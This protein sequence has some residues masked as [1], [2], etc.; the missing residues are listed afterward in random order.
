MV[1]VVSG[2]GLGLINSSFTALGGAQGSNL[3]LGQSRTLQAVNLASGNLILQDQDESLSVRGFSTNFLRTYNSQGTVAGVGQDGWVTGYERKVALTSGTLNVAGSK[4]TLY[5]GDGQSQIFTYV[6]ANNYQS[7]D[8]DGAHDSLALSGTTWTYT[9][10]STRRQEQYEDHASST[11]LG[12]LKNISY[13]KSDGT[14]PAQY[15][16]I[17]NNNTATARITEVQSIDGSGSTSDAILFTYD[18]SGRLSAIS[19]REGGVTKSQVSYGYDGVGRLSWI[20]QDLTPTVSGDNTWDAATASNNNGLRFRT[21]YTYVTT[22]STDLRIASV[23]QSDGSTISYTYDASSRIQTVSMGGETST[24][25]YTA[26]QTDVTDSITGRTWSYIYDANKQLTQVLAPAIS[27]QRDTTSYTYDA[28]GNVTQVK[29]IRASTVLSQV[30]YSYD[31]NGN[32]LWQWNRINNSDASAIAVQRTYNS[33]NQVLTETTFTGIDSDGVGVALPSGGLVKNFIYDAQNRLRFTV[34][35]TGQVTEQVYAATGNGIGQAISTR[36]YVGNAYIGVMDDT[37]LSAWSTTTKASS[38]LTEY[39]YDVKGRLQQS[40]AYATVNASG[41]GVLDISTVITSYGYDAQNL[42]LQQISVRGSGRTTT[43][44]ST[45]PTGS[46]VT[47]YAY[48]GMGRLLS[49]LK[50]DISSAAGTD[51]LTVAS[52]YTYLDSGNQI[53]ITQDSGATQTQTRNSA[54]RVVSETTAGASMV[55]RTTNNYYDGAGQLRASKDASGGV[56]YYFYDAKGRLEGTVDPTGAVAQFIYDGSDRILST[57][58]YANAVTTTTWLSGSVVTKALFADIGVVA[59]T[60]K[61]RI[62]T[63][64]YDVV[65]RLLSQTDGAIGSVDRKIINYSYDGASRVTQVQVTDSLGTA[66]TARTSRTLYDAAG[67]VLATIDAEGY[68]SENTYDASGLLLSTIRYANKSTNTTATSVATLRPVLDSSNDQTTR[69]YFDGRGQLVGVLDAQGILAETIVDELGNTR[70]ELRYANSITWVDGDSL[71]SLRSRAGS[72]R[73]LTRSAYNGLGQLATQTNVEGTVTRFSYDEAGRLVRTEVAADTTDVR[74]NFSRY[75]VFDEVIGE[76]SGEQAFAAKAVSANNPSGLALNDPTLTETQKDALY[77]A[78]GV[79]HSLDDLGRRIESI[80]A[81]GNKT[82]YFYDAS[83]RQ[84]FVVRGSAQNNSGVS[85]A[86]NAYAEVIETRYDAFGAV[87]DSIAYTGKITVTTPGSRTSVATAIGTLT[88][89]ASVDSKRSLSYTA[90]GLLASQTDAEGVQSTFTY[91]AFG[92]RS[93]QV[94]ANATTAQL[95]QSFVYDK[96]GLLLSNSQSGSGV[97]TRTSSQSYDAFGRII[98][99]I[100]ARGSSRTVTYDRL[101]RVLSQNMTVSGQVESIASSYD[102]YSRVLSVTD[103]LGKVTSYSYNDATRSMTI[104]SPEGVVVSTVHNRHGQSITVSDGLNQTISTSYDKNGNVLSVTDALNH[105]TNNTYD[106]R[107]MLLQSTD[108]DGNSVL[109]SYDAAGRVLTRAVDPSGLNLITQMKYDGQGRSVQVTDAAGR[110][111]AYSYD[112]EGRLT[113]LSVDSSGLNLRTKYSYDAAGRQTTVEEGYNGTTAQK[114]TRYDYDVLGRRTAEHVDPNGLNITT[115]YLYD[116][117]DN[118]IKR[119]DAAGNI[120][121]FVYDE[122]NRQRY[123]IGAMGSVIETAYDKTG[124]VLSS[125]AYVNVI[126]LTAA[127][128]TSLESSTGIAAQTL[129]AGKLLSNAADGL[130]NYIY[131]ND[132]RLKQVGDALGYLT[133]YSYDAAGNRRS[134]TDAMGNVTRYVYDVNNQLR[135]S[136]DAL[137]TVSETGYDNSGQVLSVR[138]YANAISLTAG[139][140]T[141]LNTGLA[142]AAQSLVAGKLLANNALDIRQSNTYDNAGRLKQVTDALGNF[143]SYTYNA[144]GN[145]VT[146]TNKLGAVWTYAYDAA[147]RMTSETSPVVM[148]TTANDVGVVT[149]ISRSVVTQIVYDIIGN[150]IKRIEDA[151]GSG[152]QARTT[153]YFYD[154]AG[155]Q[156]KTIFPDAGI[157]NSSGVLVT[158]GIKPQIEVSFNALN[159]A[160]VQK[161]VR[162]NHAYK[163]YDVLGRLAYDVDA[164]GY[165]SKYSFDALGQQTGLVRYAA[166]INTG[167][168]VGW[169]AGQAIS[170]SQIQTASVLATGANDRTIT[171]A[172]DVRGYKASVLLSAIVAYDM[173]G[174]N[175]SAATPT[176][177][178]TYNALGQLVKESVLVQQSPTAIWANTYHYYDAAGRERMTVDAEGYVSET[179]YNA[180]GQATEVIQYARAINTATLTQ[181][182]APSPPAAGDAASGYDRITRYSYDA[183]GRKTSETVVSHYQNAD[184]S[185]AVRDVA[186]KLNYDAESRVIKL[187]VD[188]IDTQTQYDALGRVINVQEAERDVLRSDA[189][190]KIVGSV[191]LDLNSSS[192]Y[193]RSSPYT[194]LTYDAFGNQVKV[195][196]YANGLRNGVLTADAA[197]DQTTI[198]RYDYQGRSVMVLDTLGNKT[199]SSYDAADNV[200]ESW[201]RLEGNDGRFSEVRTTAQYDKVGHQTNSQTVR[202][203]Y[204]TLNGSTVSQS[205]ANDAREFVSYNAFGEVISKGFDGST[206]PVLFSYDNAGRL[207]SSNADGG[208]LKTYGYSVSGAQVRESHQALAADNTVT[209]AVTLQY[210]DKL[211][212]AIRFNTPSYSNTISDSATVI[213][214]LDRW[215]NVLELT[216]PRGYLTRMEYNA[217]NQV[218]RTITP[219]VLVVNEDGTAVMRQPEEFTY[220]DALGRVIAERDAN[221][222]IDRTEYNAV[223]QVS[224]TID[225]M[226]NKTLT[227]FDALGNQR[228]NQDA[229]G[230]ITYQAFDKL[231]RVSE[232]GDFLPTLDGTRR[233]QLAME[234]YAINQLGA[235]ISVTDAANAI[236]KYDYDSR[237]LL[238]RSE[239]ALGIK[240]EY[241]YDSQGRKIREINALSDASLAPNPWSYQT[242]TAGSSTWS[243]AVPTIE[244]SSKTA[245]SYQGQIVSGYVEPVLEY[246][247]ETGQTWVITEGYTVYRSLNAGDWIQFNAGSQIFSGTAPSTPSYYYM[248]V[249]KTNTDGSNETKTFIVNV[250]AGSGV[251]TDSDGEQVRLHEQTWDYDAFGRLI[252]HNDLSGVDYNYNYNAITNQQISQSSGWTTSS[253]ATTATSLAGAYQQYLNDIVAGSYSS[254]GNRTFKFYT[255]GLVKEISEGSNV[256]RYEYDAAGN[257]TLEESDITDANGDRVKL[258][259]QMTYDSHNRLEHIMQDD[260]TTTTKRI[261]DLVYSYDANGNRRRVQAQGA[262]L[263]TAPAI[264]T[265]NRAPVTTATAPISNKTMKSGVAVSF[266]ILL[267]DVFRDADLDPLAISVTQNNGNPL[268]TWLTTSIDSATGELV[269][270]ASNASVLGAYDIKVKAT[271]TNHGASNLSANTVFRINVVTNSA[272]ALLTAGTET[273]NLKLNQAMSLELASAAYFS[274][275]D[276]G[277]SLTLSIFSVSPAAPWLQIDASNPNA[278]RLSGT[279][280]SAG[281]YTIKLRGTDASGAFVD[282]TISLVVSANTAPVGLTQAAVNFVNGRTFSWSQPLSSV[283]TDIDGNISTLTATLADG[284]ALPNWMSLETVYKADGPYLV[285][286]GQSPAGTPNN[287]IYGVKFTAVDAMGLSGSTQMNVLFK[288]NSAPTVIGTIPAQR[289]FRS[290]PY[291]ATLAL[292]SLFSDTD[293]DSLDYSVVLPANSA[294]ASWLSYVVDRDAGTIT[295]SGTPPSMT[296]AHTPLSYV[297]KTSMARVPAL[298]SASI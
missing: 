230:Y 70:A 153:E 112:R 285:L 5:T 176:T 138:T 294:L 266:R 290:V 126:S 247:Q 161:D 211:G 264:S 111:T 200:L 260:F 19:T 35:A 25:T 144:V 135:Y 76:I 118:V 92:E 121:R 87:R 45:P 279:P 228:L 223:G 91:N 222:N 125:R 49:I 6:S 216:D 219:L 146:K 235:R 265:A 273:K 276:L 208:V 210:I 28:S 30:D 286:A 155:R 198:S 78:Y 96:R 186:T 27:G 271:E 237:N 109:Y 95:T 104:T 175:S 255:N 196:R 275:A 287:T 226:G 256:Y 36:T 259:T 291:T 242:I 1:A 272:P 102:A 44:T 246:D 7:T 177:Q 115:N 293:T 178:F 100:D 204:R 17:Y 130:S 250:L 288:N 107:G 213:Q 174:A 189:E 162:G 43:Y 240:M 206:Q 37:S 143:E 278:I 157:I 41:V 128:I 73:Q 169:S 133:T 173:T 97:T 26:N 69:F 80:D 137:G 238:V 164:E 123:S 184:G 83:S 105:T 289:I 4:M 20:Q 214:R 194:A 280:T 132:G 225:A 77:A 145:R 139:D 21:T 245:S 253:V 269:F 117:N 171:T 205:S 262:L 149:N 47:S 254:T 141:T 270:T 81:Q 3:L 127:N 68:V 258:R 15:N 61:D 183:L 9:E 257:R 277:D 180:L 229:N 60:N 150:V 151:T 86:Q 284:S 122:A 152:A 231:G 192:L 268:P 168:M 193:E 64:I 114:T 217:V 113:L 58:R 160:V 281:T 131:D 53:V 215:G 88:F 14:T 191:V 66:G 71:T 72:S 165:V 203:G 51:S 54:G 249:T 134:M 98:S 187:G 227:A 110:T 292:S 63:S 74:E 267:T 8:S 170:L 154:A 201:Y 93:Q 221:G 94:N 67:R 23:T 199:Y 119:T 84:T 16:V 82:W 233:T 181:T 147:G 224:D 140:I 34:D 62:Q 75:N 212:R 24:F 234:R 209:T 296:R 239:S 172:Y 57:V 197:R 99:T 129:I 232:H 148:V 274:D 236:T 18:G 32:V 59:D 42:L 120:T 52:S 50:R 90:R 136:I 156:I 33:S 13:L 179:E 116:G 207:I 243:F 46:E 195:T 297:H 48:D 158:T 185:A 79:R 124:R 89:L 188:G 55:S 202:N 244:W 142:S 182:V 159:Q 2:N 65:G 283:F 108:M 106:V 29:T 85:G 298:R 261:L 282:K 103:A 11:L 10:G 167:L 220:Y 251:V 39:S 163:V 218:T 263:S 12:R 22:S 190:E 101:G 38:Q 248:R 166:K 56:T 241:V 40:I 31:S 295:F 252:D